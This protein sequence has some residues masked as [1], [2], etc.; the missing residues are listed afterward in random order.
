AAAAF[1]DPALLEGGGAPAAAALPI[2][3]VPGDVA[4]IKFSGDFSPLPDDS[5]DSD[6]SVLRT[7]VLPDLRVPV[8]RRTM[9][10]VRAFTKT[11]SG[12]QSFLARYRRAGAYREIVER[13]LRDAGLPE[14]IEW[15]AAI[16]S[17]FDTRA[18]SPKG[19]AGLWQ[20]MPET[21]QNY[22]LY[23]SPYV[24]ERMSLVRS[25]QA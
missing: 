16:E 6:T 12:R 8:T 20:F 18:V 19:A 11:E 10:Y 1:R 4:E 15:V 5:T 9:R 3:A 21:G 22:G 13:A 7:L 14:D 24:D 2:Q 23:Q 17:G 25:S